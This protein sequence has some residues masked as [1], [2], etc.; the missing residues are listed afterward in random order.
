MKLLVA[1]SDR[2][3]FAGILKR[4][5][6]RGLTVLLGGHEMLLVA[7]GVGARCAAAAVDS[8]LFFQPEAVVSTGFCGALD[9]HLKIADIVVAS[10]VVSSGGRRFA[11]KPVTGGTACAVFSAD[12]VVQ[13][14]AEKAELAASGFGA[15]EMEAAGAASRAEAL[16]LPFYCIRAVSDLAG[17]DMANDFNRTLTP[18]GHFDTMKLLQDSF[19]SPLARIPELLR[20]R[21]RCVRAAQ[22]LGEFFADC[23]F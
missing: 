3:E 16:R 21:K 18:D 23:R 15:V 9:P 13:T 2:M 17:E 20:L 19:R 12:H 8:G 5:K 4:A 6:T 11:A 7:N 10:C 14:A 1:A 22:A